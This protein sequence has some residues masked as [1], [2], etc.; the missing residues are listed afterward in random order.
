MLQ[1]ESADIKRGKQLPHSDAE[2]SCSGVMHR[3]CTPRAFI[4]PTFDKGPLLLFVGCKL[5]N[6][7]SYAVEAPPCGRLLYSACPGILMIS[8]NIR[9]VLRHLRERTV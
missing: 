9:L 3:I 2:P 8:A 4:I 5:A 6:I 7:E 1:V